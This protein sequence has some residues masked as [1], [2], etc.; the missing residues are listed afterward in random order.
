MGAAILLFD[1]HCRLCRAGARRLQALAR[2]GAIET[3]D[4]QQQGVLAAFPGLTH[5]ECMRAMV[6]VRPDG[7]RVH[8]ARAV[9]EALRTRALTSWLA[10]V[11]CLPGVRQLADAAYV[12]IAAHR[13]KLLGR[14]AACD[15]AGCA[16]H[17]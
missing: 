13:Y 7:Q 5:A 14:A 9:V 3:R 8:A 2:P 12:W 1:G 6:L 17:R 15:E 4:F 16:L 10:W 11:Y